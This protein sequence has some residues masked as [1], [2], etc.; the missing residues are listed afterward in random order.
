M[1]DV[2]VKERKIWDVSEK[3]NLRRQYYEKGFLENNMLRK[4]NTRLQIQQEYL[5]KHLMTTLTY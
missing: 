1:C 4:V 5:E 3:V 2:R